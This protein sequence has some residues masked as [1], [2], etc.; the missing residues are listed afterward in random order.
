MSNFEQ[1]KIYPIL[2]YRKVSNKISQF[3]FY[4][5][6]LG[7]SNYSK[8]YKEIKLLGFLVFEKS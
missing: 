5:L 6:L 7:I 2:I 3:F 4:H 8:F 1:L